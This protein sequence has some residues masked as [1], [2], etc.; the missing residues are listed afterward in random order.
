MSYIT[1]VVVVAMSWEDEAIAHVNKHLMA[2][3]QRQQIAPLGMDAA[4]GRKVASSRVYA[5]AFNYVDLAALKDALLA[6]PW[7]FPGWV[8][9]C[10]NDEGSGFERLTLEK[11]LIPGELLGAPRPCTPSV[12]SRRAVRCPAVLALRC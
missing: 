5:A 9:V 7:R 1:D 8:T 3:G 2:A 4:G 12:S 10:I 6:A 11:G